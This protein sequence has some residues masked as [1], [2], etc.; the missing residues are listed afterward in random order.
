MLRVPVTECGVLRTDAADRP[1]Q[2][3]DSDRGKRFG[4]CAR[5]E[6]D[7]GFDGVIAEFTDETSFPVM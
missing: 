2:V 7:N 3:L 6:V 5:E 1:A 4:N